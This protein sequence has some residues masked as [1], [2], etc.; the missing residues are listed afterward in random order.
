MPRSLGVNV[1]VDQTITPRVRISGGYTFTRGT[2]VA[3]GKN[4][5]TP[6]NGVRPD[7]LFLNV[8]ETVSDGAYRSHEAYV[9]SSFSLVTGAAAQQPRF[10]WK[11]LSFNGSYIASHYRNNSD[12]PFAVPASG[13]LSTEWG[14]NGRA[15]RTSSAS[16]STAAS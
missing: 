14:P 3:R 2:N 16:A 7:P 9:S 6:I 10:N 8:I 11:R 4:L 1:G 12:G 13:T 15:A 5:N